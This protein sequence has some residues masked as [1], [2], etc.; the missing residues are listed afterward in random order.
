MRIQPTM[1]QLVLFLTLCLA[2]GAA[3]ADII[4]H[5]GKS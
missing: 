5:N 4:L 2:I 1:L 3:D